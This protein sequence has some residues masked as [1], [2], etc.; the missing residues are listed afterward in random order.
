MEHPTNQRVVLISYNAA[1]N[2]TN[3][4]RKRLENR[5]IY[6]LL[7]VLAIGIFGGVLILIPCARCDTQIGHTSLGIACIV[8]STLGLLFVCIDVVRSL[9]LHYSSAAGRNGGRPR[10]GRQP[11]VLRS[12]ELRE[13]VRARDVEQG[14]PMQP[15]TPTP[16]PTQPEL[17]DHGEESQETGTALPAQQSS[18]LLPPLQPRDLQEPVRRPSWEA[19]AAVRREQTQRCGVSKPEERGPPSP[20]SHKTRAS[21]LPAE[22]YEE[23]G[24][25]EV[26]NV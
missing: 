8:L 5:R 12:I 6:Y 2:P 19:V 18:L 22:H 21:E 20:P 24:D 13:S 17:V 11:A 16:T 4:A 14:H 26:V 23:D 15:P 10:R 9:H 7:A 1:R 3:A 25:W